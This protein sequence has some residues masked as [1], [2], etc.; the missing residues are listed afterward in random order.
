MSAREP[1]IWQEVAWWSIAAA[2][3]ALAVYWAGQALALW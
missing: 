2:M 1:I 3:V